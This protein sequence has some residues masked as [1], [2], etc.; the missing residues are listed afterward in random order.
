MERPRQ[1]RVCAERFVASKSRMTLYRADEVLLWV[2][3]YDSMNAE[4]FGELF[5][6]TQKKEEGWQMAKLCSVDTLQKKLERAYPRLL[7][8]LIGLQL[9]QCR[10]REAFR[11]IDELEQWCHARGR[12][13][14]AEALRKEVRA[15]CRRWQ[16]LLE[17]PLAATA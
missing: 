3:F 9:C 14:N 1:L 17:T 5:S 2:I 12:R 15:A 10:W 4:G 6:V 16:E 7:R 8:S 11:L 13:C